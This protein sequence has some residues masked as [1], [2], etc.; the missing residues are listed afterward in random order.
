MINILFSG[1]EKVFDGALTELISIT[2]RTKEPINC[3]IFTMDASNLKPEFTCITDKQI[4]FLN[5]VV[6]TKNAN[7]KVT[8]VDV[9]EIYNQEF[10]GFSIKVT[11]LY[12]KLKVIKLLT[13]VKYRL[14][15][16]L[17]IT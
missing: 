13:Y 17:L 6:K 11:L 3:Y 16:S 10:K 1:N 15:S 14:F 7:N 2:N 8:K 5:K 4:E 9:T 12:I